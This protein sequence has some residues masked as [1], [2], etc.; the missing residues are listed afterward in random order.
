MRLNQSTT[1]SDSSWSAAGNT[2][3]VDWSAT[4]DRAVAGTPAWALTVSAATVVLALLGMAYLAIRTVWRTSERARNRRR[5]DLETA[6]AEGRESEVIGLG[7]MGR[8]A[9]VALGGM[10]VSVYGLW[11]FAR[12][13]AQLPE[14]I[15]VG[16]VAMFDVM[17]LALF[18]QLYRRANPKLGWTPQLRAIHTTAW[19]LVAV[20]ATANV[21]HAPNLVAAP[22]M[23]A[24]PIGAAWVIELELRAR[25]MGSERIDDES[26]AGP[27]R[28]LVLLWTKGWAAA[29]SGL[30]LDP[31]STSGQVARAT[32]AKKAA[33]RLFKLR[34]ALEQHVKLLENREAREI[35]RRDLAKAVTEL[36]ALRRKATASMERADFALDSSQALAVLRGLAGWTRVDDVAMVDTSDTKAVTQLMEEVAILPS[37]KRIEAAERAAELEEKAD[38][39]E[40]A[41]QVA[42]DARER[43]EEAMRAAVAEKKAAE[44]AREEAREALA[45]A[46]EETQRAKAEADR[47]EE[48]RERS[49]AARKRAESKM[50]AEEKNANRLI[51][52][53]EEEKKKLSNASLELDRVRRLI[54]DE[55]SAKDATAGQVE[56]LRT[57]LQRLLNDRKSAE[58]TTHSLT[59]EAQR[60][61]GEVERLRGVLGDAQRAT[62]Q[63]TAAANQAAELRRQAEDR[64]RLA[65]ETARRTQAEA[66]EAQALLETLRP[67]L[68]E[69]LGGEAEAVALAG[70]PAFR[71][72]A[73]QAGWEEYIAAVRERRELPTA[74]EL[75]VAYDVS[76]GNA[77]NWLIEFSRIRAAM[78]A[79][80]GARQ[81]EGETE[82]SESRHA[83]PSS[84]RQESDGYRADGHERA[85]DAAQTRSINGQ[86]QPV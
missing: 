52:R 57:E 14:P 46:A 69:R 30:G 61:S 54:A 36:S 75:S 29:F 2:L 6:R 45:A 20:S 37:A 62:E 47:A 82:R 5:A 11:G 4:V 3:A 83:E 42:E 23:G 39:A 78:V 70:A 81:A 56:S 34:K 25:M 85:E 55:Q 10:I 51:E 8:Q 1:G 28:L 68:A 7:N 24:M 86:R 33:T 67:Q 50:S 73:K 26:K 35:R 53:A 13:T 60:I 32:L 59:G 49:E 43:A 18:S 38:K 63:H 17:E 21:I 66:A 74:T 31:N 44:T 16:F 22:F 72:G 71:S 80:G 76:E 64:Q 27:L 84:A 40:S 77:R 9:Y 41:R 48:A 12:F 58:D 65:D 15:A 19:V 79:N